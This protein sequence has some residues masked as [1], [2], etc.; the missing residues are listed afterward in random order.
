M[1]IFIMLGLM[2]VCLGIYQLTVDKDEL[3]QR[4]ERGLRMRGI[5]NI[6]RT[7]EWE[8]RQV[9]SGWFSISLAIVFMIGGYFLWAS[10][11]STG[12]NN[13]DGSESRCFIDGKPVDCDSF[14]FPHSRRK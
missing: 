5:V 10:L 4:Q 1:W 11:Q 3:W 12:P 7:P 2:F 13:R 9:T 8:K 14:P 6:E